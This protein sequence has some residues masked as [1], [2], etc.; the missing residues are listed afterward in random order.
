MPFPYHA[1]TELKP[2]LGPNCDILVDGSGVKFQE[3]AKRRSDID[4]ETPVVIL[5]PTSEEEIQ[6]IVSYLCLHPNT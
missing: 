1:I 3:Y 6:K 5:L 4:R 2:V